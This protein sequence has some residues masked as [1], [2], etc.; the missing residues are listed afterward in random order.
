MS[1]GTFP[2][3]WLIFFFFL[4]RHI[5]LYSSDVEQQIY[6][7]TYSGNIF[8]EEQIKTETALDCEDQYVLGEMNL[9]IIK[10]YLLCLKVCEFHWLSALDSFHQD[11]LNC[12]PQ[13][14]QLAN[15]IYLSSNKSHVWGYT[16][17]LD[18]H[19]ENTPIQ[20]Y[21]KKKSPKTNFSDK[22]S[23]IFHISAQNID[24]GYSLEPPK[25]FCSKHRLWI[26]IRTASL[27]R[28]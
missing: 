28:F 22:N 25:Y 15:T 11:F 21:W 1:K 4:W 16:F 2:D 5:H 19:Y 8:S 9:K 14:L 10:V 17:I 18:K 27:R 24:Y 3:C 23:D 20:I 13:W 12:L 6:G 7:D 26:L